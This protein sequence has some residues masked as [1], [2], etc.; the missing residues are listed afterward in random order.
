MLISRFLVSFRWVFLWGAATLALG[1]LLILGL[2]FDLHDSPGWQLALYYLMLFVFVLG[3]V[4]TA[5]PSVLPLFPGAAGKVDWLIVALL[6]LVM[7]GV[8][9][10]GWLRGGAYESLRDPRLFSLSVLFVFG[11]IGV[12]FVV[13]MSRIG[14]QL[15]LRL[16]LGM[17]ESPGPRWL[18]QLDSSGKGKVCEIPGR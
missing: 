2:G 9:L 16:K 10:F 14:R 7:A 6:A 4:I 18:D 3:P 17:W 1:L 8:L 15:F 12:V 11:G 13:A 5:A